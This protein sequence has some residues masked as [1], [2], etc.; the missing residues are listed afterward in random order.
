[1]LDKKS[2]IRYDSQNLS[3]KAPFHLQDSPMLSREDID[4]FQKYENEVMPFS[5]PQFIGALEKHISFDEFIK[6]KGLDKK[7]AAA[8]SLASQHLQLKDK[9]NIENP[10]HQQQLGAALAIQNSPESWKNFD[11]K[12][13]KIIQDMLITKA[14]WVNREIE[15]ENFVKKAV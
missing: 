1:M 11:A 4:K 6:L 13:Q 12:H 8:Y 3:L 7:Y 10:I 9:I 14:Q 15:G 2:Y 5:K